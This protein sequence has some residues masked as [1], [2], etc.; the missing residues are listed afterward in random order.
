MRKTVPEK[1]E[2]ARYKI[3]GYYNRGFEGAFRLMGPY[4]ARLHIVSSI[5][6]D[7]ASEGWEH[8]SVST[9]RRLPNWNEMCLVKDLF[10]DEEEVVFQLHPAKSQYVNNHP[11][12]LH[13]WRHP[14]KPVPLPPSIL[15]GIASEGTL[16]GPAHAREVE[17]RLERE[18]KLTRGTKIETPE[19]TPWEQIQE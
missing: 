16:R 10:W 12:C 3:P 5:G 19:L 13:M 14:T 7:P 6:T 9:E 2:Q 4:G 17:A 11:T 18:G 15:V 8:V 1:L